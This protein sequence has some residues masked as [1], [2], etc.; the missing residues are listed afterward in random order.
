MA[1]D[2]NTGDYKIFRDAFK[3]F[4]ATEIIPYY[5]Q[6]EEA[7]LVPREVWLKC[8]EQGYLCP[9]VEEEYGG[10]G[11]DF[12]YSVIIAEELARAGTHVMFPLHSDIV[13]PYIHS[14]GTTEQKRKW[15]PGCVSGEI[16]AAVAMTE[17]DTGSDLSAIKTVAVKDGDHYIL[18][19][20]KTF[21]SGGE[22]CDLVIVA[23]KTDSRANPPHR[24]ISL[25]VVENGTPG[26]QKGRRLHKMGLKSQDTVELFFE[27]CRVPAANLLGNEGAGFYYL[28]QK[29][30]QER[31]VATIG[32][33][34]LAEKMLQEAI[35]YA[36]GRTIFGK[37]VA[38]FQHNTFK[39][40]EMATEV[41]LGRVFLDRLIEE[42][43]AGNN[44]VKRVSMA[45]YWITEMANRVAYHC[46]QLYGG[47]GYIEEY[48]ICRDYRDIRVQTIYAGSTEVMK[49][50]IAKELGL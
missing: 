3:K 37:P 19:G 9:W 21:I 46:L 6:W 45:K 12:G 10:S 11:A 28:M 17:P 39:L 13:V 20:A 22:N 4:I 44:V 42:H 43:M 38:K 14:F 8:G 29:L 7:G 2:F 15:L 33:Q 47:Y 35:D 18:N 31:L 24:G 1:L 5:Q 34:A 48:P 36:C 16:I 26:F 49:S 27:N 25:I 50:I 30:Q 32:A 41:E 40:V 23:C